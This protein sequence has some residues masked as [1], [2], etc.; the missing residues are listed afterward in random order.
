MPNALITL[1]SAVARFSRLFTG[2][3]VLSMATHS[4]A[5]DTLSTP[6]TR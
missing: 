2:W 5:T 3:K 1:R 6:T 4:P